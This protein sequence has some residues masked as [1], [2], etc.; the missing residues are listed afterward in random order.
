[1]I[2]IISMQNPI[3][4]TNGVASHIRDLYQ[5]IK[6]NDI[7]VNIIHPYNFDYY[8]SYFTDKILK[9]F[10]KLFKLLKWEIL[11]Y[12]KIQLIVFILKNKIQN[13]PAHVKIINVH[14]IIS[15][16]ALYSLNRKF[17]HSFYT[18]HANYEPD[19]E[20]IQSGYFNK[21]SYIF[22]KFQS[23]CKKA[24]TIPNLTIA[25]VS[26]HCKN[27]YEER[28][29]HKF[30]NFNQVIKIIQMGVD[31]KFNIDENISKQISSIGEY[32]INVG[33]VTDIKNQLRLAEIAFEFQ[34]LGIKK[35][36]VLIGEIDKSYYLILKDYLLQHNL[37][38][39]FYFLGALSRDN[40]YQWIAH[41]NLNI[42]TAKMES[43]G[44]CI[45]ESMGLG[46]PTFAFYYPTLQ[47][48]FYNFPE[49]ILDSN[50]NTADIVRKIRLIE[51]KNM[52][53]RL[54]ADKQRKECISIYPRSKIINHLMEVYT[55]ET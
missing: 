12:F 1:M 35:N 17:P 28:M 7:E 50:Q 41:A 29:N 24:Y 19:I 6:S 9:L 20:F 32:I 10:S 15:L 40:A 43:F 47:E 11:F 5:E 48:I 2:A 54:L 42:H 14:D 37:D 27:L 55:K 34:K 36:F 38:E 26:K 39:C 16:I 21:N 18:L 33:K 22:K 44:L 45:I 13:L 46:C 3:R 51:D 53:F 8:N 31:L 52:G 4:D 49:A 25:C 30:E 23:E